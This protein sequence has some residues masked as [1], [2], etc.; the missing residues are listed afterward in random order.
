MSRLKAPQ[1]KKQIIDVATRIF[2]RHGYNAATTHAIAEAAGVTEPILY[3]H[4]KGKQDMFVA[5][6]RQMSRQTLSHWQELIA[7]E[8][9][10]EKQIRLIARE[11]PH[12]QQRLA[13]A[14]NVIHGALATSHDRKVTGVLR[15]HYARTEEFF[16]S[17]IRRGQ[18]AG[19]FR[20]D[21][22]PT[23]PAWQLINVGI[24]FSMV[25][26]N[27]PQA[28]HFSPTKAIEF[29]LRAMKA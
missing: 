21:L 26:L 2:A 4:F 25:S 7:G 3:R 6:T 20:K 12:H 9:S 8:P 13:D 29:I 5:I 19:Q 11:F 14:Y 16:I 18:E 24:G 10:P 1:R 28:D 22:D 17:I 27:L 15:E 23:V